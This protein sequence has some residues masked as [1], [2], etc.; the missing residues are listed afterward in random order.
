MD[1]S[2]RPVQAPPM[3]EGIIA[4]IAGRFVLVTKQSLILDKYDL[5][6]NFIIRWFPA[7]TCGGKFNRDQPSLSSPSPGLN[8]GIDRGSSPHVILEL[9]Y[10][11]SIF[12]K[13]DS[14]SP[15][16]RG[17]ASENDRSRGFFGL[18]MIVYI[19]S[20]WPWVIL[21]SSFVL[22]STCS[23]YSVG[24]ESILFVIWITPSLSV[25]L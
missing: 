10:R 19:Y 4:V 16:A 8:R 17:Q 2:S 18:L 20:D 3:S 15:L 5:C 9:F 23:R 25:H 22:C 13:L 12:E 14:H 1:P 11:G 7:K 21:L 6:S 24:M